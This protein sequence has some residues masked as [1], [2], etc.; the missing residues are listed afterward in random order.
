VLKFQTR[1]FDFPPYGH[2]I[3]CTLG[4]GQTVAEAITAIVIFWGGGIE[5]CCS[6]PQTDIRHNKRYCMAKKLGDRD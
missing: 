2:L 1:R 3:Q 4:K 5:M 6:T